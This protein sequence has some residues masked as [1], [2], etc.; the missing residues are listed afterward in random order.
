LDGPAPPAAFSA[1]PAIGALDTG[2]ADAERGEA[3]ADI[4][5]GIAAPATAV[6]D[7]PLQETPPEAVAALPAPE[8]L[9]DIDA[10]LDLAPLPPLPEDL[11][12]SREETER[13]YAEDGIWPRTPDRPSFEPFQIVDDT[14]LASIDPEVTAFDAVALGDP[15]INPGELLR[16]VPPPPPFGAEITRDARGLVAATPE[17]VLTPEGAFV[18]L[19][20][21]PV[22]AIPRPRE[23]APAIPETPVLDADEAVLG[24][25]TPSPRPAD[26]D[27]T[28]ERQLLGGLSRTELAGLRPDPRPL[29][30]QE[31]AAQA[32][33][34]PQQQSPGDAADP[35]AQDITGTP[36]AVTSSR[37]PRSRPAEIETIVA[38]A[39][40]VPATAVAATAVAPPPSIPSNADVSRAATES[41][42]I[43]L[44]D[45]NL[46]G[47]TGTSSNRRALVRLPSGRFVRVGVGDRLDG[48]RVAAIGEASLQYVRNGRNVTLEIPG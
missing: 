8:T 4:S 13:I 30:A 25:F 44:R 17:G 18:V 33:L 37:L 2:A 41:N 12:P 23:V 19:G 43:R 7:A 48:G 9:P 32:S 20:R 14:Y 45:I 10:D 15:G 11:L 3:E 39:A 40:R 47:V 34:F 38:A 36:L 5:S 16:R 1:P 35:V 28:R 22:D 24:T 6:P 29:S 31:S 46:I 27:E 26:L 21:P 42:A